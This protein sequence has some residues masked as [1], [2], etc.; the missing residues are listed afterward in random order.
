M[1]EERSAVAVS[2]T[3]AGIISKELPNAILY[4]LQNILPSSLNSCDLIIRESLM[5]VFEV[6]LKFSCHLDNIFKVTEPH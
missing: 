4:I 6:F 2:F 3:S 1:S 5:D